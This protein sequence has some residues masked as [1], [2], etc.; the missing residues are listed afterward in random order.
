MLPKLLYQRLGEMGMDFAVLYPTAALRI[1]FI[2][3]EETRKATCR[4]F[5][6]FSAEQFREF[7]D[8]LTPVAMIPMYT[9]KEAIV[10][11]EYAVKNLGLKVAMM[12]AAAPPDSR[13]GRSRRRAQ[14]IRAVARHARA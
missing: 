2:A 11:L 6:R 5:N 4:A 14:S 12:P 10:E 7:S 9:P 13:G 1:P 8:R 3:D